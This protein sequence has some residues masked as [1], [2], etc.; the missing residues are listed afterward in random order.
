[1]SPRD[2]LDVDEGPR[3][4]FKPD[5]DQTNLLNSRQFQDGNMKGASTVSQSSNPNNPREKKKKVRKNLT[6]ILGPDANKKIHLCN[7]DV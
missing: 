7:K 3:N 6:E 2:D 5:M 4:S 1:M